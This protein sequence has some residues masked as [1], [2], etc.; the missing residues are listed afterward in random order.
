MA[1]F[2]TGLL[3]TCRGFLELSGFVA[4]EL[5]AFLIVRF[6]YL[7]W[8]AA[9]GYALRIFPIKAARLADSSSGLFQCL[10]QYLSLSV[11]V[12]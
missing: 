8:E 11:V 10:G 2:S 9:S 6:F 1:E 12:G 5:S 7:G 3:S 4:H